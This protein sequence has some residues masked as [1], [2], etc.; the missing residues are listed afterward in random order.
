MILLSAMSIGSLISGYLF[1][2]IPAFIGFTVLF[3]GNTTSY[4]HTSWKEIANIKVT[5]QENQED[6]NSNIFRKDANDIFSPF[7]MLGALFLDDEVK[8]D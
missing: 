1:L 3:A 7:N 6:Y 5:F 4:D 8:S 2:L